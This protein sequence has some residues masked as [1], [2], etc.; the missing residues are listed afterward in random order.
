MIEPFSQNDWRLYHSI[1]GEDSEDVERYSYNDFRSYELSHHGILGQ[2]WGQRNGPPY[3]LQPGAYS[4]AERKAVR[5]DR[6]DLDELVITTA[7]Y[8]IPILTVLAVKGVKEIKTRNKISK[9]EHAYDDERS[10]ASV[11]SK[12]GLKTKTTKLSEKEDI[13]RINPG[14]IGY[15]D[16]D[17]HGHTSNCTNCTVA[18]QLR[19]RGYEVRAKKLN[20]GRN[21]EE[22]IKKMFPGCKTETIED[23]PDLKKITNSKEREKLYNDYVRDHD[24]LAN[25]G[26]NYP[27][28]DKVISRMSQ[29]PAGSSGQM[30]IKWNY[31]SGHSVAYEVTSSGEFRIMDGQQAKIYSGDDVRKLLATTTS[32]RFQRLDNLDFDTK[33]V[34]EAVE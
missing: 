19:Q 9:L 33:A 13:K 26:R 17:S 16:S 10:K 32:C 15:E 23:Y 29:E 6:G 24:D 11:D 14:F 5:S 30:L 18:Y 27:L 3:P 20:D 2:K 4:A 1:F 31:F 25:I 21:G 34:R 22:F 7:V 28:A 12:T 8:A